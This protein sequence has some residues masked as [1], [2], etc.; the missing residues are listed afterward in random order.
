[1]PLAIRHVVRVADAV[2]RHRSL[3]AELT[4]LSHRRIPLA[5]AVDEKTAEAYIAAAHEARK[6]S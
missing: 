4:V 1:V 5:V 6:N 2:T 3:S